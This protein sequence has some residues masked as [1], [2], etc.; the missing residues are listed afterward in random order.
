MTSPDCNGVRAD[1]DG[2]R[3]LGELSRR[4]AGHVGSIE[5]Y[6]HHTC[7]ASGAFQGVMTFFHGTYSAVIS[8]ASEGLGGAKR[9]HEFAAQNFDDSAA[10]YETADRGAY[11]VLARVAGG[12][13]W[14]IDPYRA[15][16][17]GDHTIGLGSGVDAPTDAEWK[18]PEAGS[19]LGEEL[20]ADAKAQGIAELK[21]MPDRLT[22]DTVLVDGRRVF[23]DDLPEGFEGVD[24]PDRIGKAGGFLD[25]VNDPLGLS[26]KL[27]DFKSNAVDNRVDHFHEHGG[28]L[29]EW[30]QQGKYQLD[31][32]PNAVGA[33]SIKD[34]AHHSYEEHADLHHNVREVAGWY[35]GVP[36][37]KDYVMSFKD[38]PT[39]GIG[40]S[41]DGLKESWH[42][43]KE[44]YGAAHEQ[45]DSSAL[46]WSKR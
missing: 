24:G 21:S 15:A 22:R 29:G 44:V 40:Q 27:D 28:K 34:D 46:D 37:A 8:A 23:K 7:E 16:G 38:D 9:T 17:S 4:Q 10:A 35:D 13:G 19:S 6:L 31:Q 36:D 11:D 43:A 41:V 5:E 2:V 42:G 26:K 25:K 18:T 12:A 20:K 3:A 39:G 45:T 14:D 1:L 30:T 32:A 33:G